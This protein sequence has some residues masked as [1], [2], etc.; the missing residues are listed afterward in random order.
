MADETSDGAS[1]ETSRGAFER[2]LEAFLRHDQRALE[3][4]A[5]EGVGVDLRDGEGAT[6]LL[7]AAALGEAAAVEWIL[8]A[9][10]EVDVATP[11]EAQ[12]PGR[13]AFHQAAAGGHP[14]TAAVIL[15]A[16][17]APNRVDGEGASALMLAAAGGHL[18]T[19]RFL[20]RSGVDLDLEN[21]RGQTA[22]SLA[23]RAGHGEIFALL[24]ALGAAAGAPAPAPPP[25]AEREWQTPGTAQILLQSAGWQ[26]RPRGAVPTDDMIDEEIEDDV[27]DQISD[28]IEDEMNR[29][30]DRLP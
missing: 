6:V 20:V 11:L 27:G 18:E 8:Q 7:R 10:A 16:G 19:V 13:T 22:R 17:A 1:D 28:W 15:A 12:S 5:A 14:Q 3:G 21:H 29:F 26:G 4:L 24:Q 25:I 23:R 9:G 30:E 2:L